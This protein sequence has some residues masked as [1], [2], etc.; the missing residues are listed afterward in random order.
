MVH[1]GLKQLLKKK[2]VEHNNMINNKKVIGIILAYKHA[3]FLDGLYK[4]LPLHIMDEVI[5]TNDESGDGIEEVAKRLGIKC[6]SHPRMGYGGNMKY[7]MKKAIE[8]GADYMVEIHG[9]GQFDVDFIEPAINKIVGGGYGLV[10]GNRFVNMKQPLDDGMPVIKYIANRCLTFIENITI[11]V[12][13]GEFHTGARI[14]SKE[15]IEKVDLT[16]TSDSF[17]FG[18]EIIAQIIYHKFKVGEVP[19]RSYYNREHSS[20]SFKN[21]ALYAFQT[22]RT[23]FLY[24]CARIGFKTKLFYE[25]KN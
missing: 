18:F 22:F 11:G 4:K 17:L 2:L 24:I 5:I 9:D 16:H 23:L 7:G 14:Y 12:W 13:L 21:S 3:Q 15:A 8:L 1:H 10:L 20:M 19:V 6:F 25:N